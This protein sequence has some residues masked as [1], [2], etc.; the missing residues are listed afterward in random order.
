M[1]IKMCSTTSDSENNSIPDDDSEYIIS[2]QIGV[3]FFVFRCSCGNCP[4]AHLENENE[5]MCRKDFDRC[6]DCLSD[7]WVLQEMTTSKKCITL[8]PGFSPD[9]LNRWSLRLFALKYRT[10]NTK[11]Y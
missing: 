11:S 2:Q 3:V 10:I 5:C 4:T 6:V 8:H 9:C 7:Q 1:E